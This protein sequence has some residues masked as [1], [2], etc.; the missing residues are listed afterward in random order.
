M[1]IR[2]LTAALVFISLILLVPAQGSAKLSVSYASDQLSSWYPPILEGGCALSNET[3][4]FFAFPLSTDRDSFFQI[5][6]QGGG[7]YTFTDLILYV[8]ENSSVV[9]PSHPCS[10]EPLQ[11]SGQYIKL[12]LGNY[13]ILASGTDF[14]RFVLVSILNTTLQFTVYSQPT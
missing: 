9:D 7:G 11:V 10:V 3:A 1:Q 5:D 6:V 14:V 4:S 8:Y 12:S 13:W 2:L